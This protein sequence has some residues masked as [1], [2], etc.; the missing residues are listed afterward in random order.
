MNNKPIKTNNMAKH[1]KQ[2]K[3]N[4]QKQAN[5]QTNIIYKK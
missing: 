1:K 5:Q 4:K 2:N 3:N